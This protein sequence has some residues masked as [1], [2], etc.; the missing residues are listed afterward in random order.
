MSTTTVHNT[1]VACCTV[2]PVKSDYVPKGTYKAYGGISKVYVTG[3]EKVGDIAI[4][5]VYDI[6][7][8]KPQTQQGADILAEQL[9]AQ[10]LIPDFF[11]PAGPWP[12]EHFPPKTNEEKAGLQ[13]FFG[14]PAHPQDSVAKLLTV[15]RALKADGAKFVGTYG[16]CWGGKVTILSGSQ[17]GTPF[18]AVAAVHPAMLSAPDTEN[19]QVP[20]GLYPT[21]D[22]SY[23]EYE[24]MLSIV[25]KKPFAAKNDT[26]YYN[27]MFHGF[28]GAR[29]DLNNAEN[30]KFFEDLYGNLIKFYTNVNGMHTH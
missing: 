13:A 19:L 4:V 29:A 16:L 12:L 1:N 11:E 15:G 5:C 17:T 6:F 2:P 20:L 18:D 8:F 25:S 21:K 22:E 27:E 7:G 30:K 23:E 24:K 3:P 28:A 26:K 10:V 14:G 9:K